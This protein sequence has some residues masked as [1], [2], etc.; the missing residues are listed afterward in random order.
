M[1][2]RIMTLPPKQKKPIFEKKFWERPPPKD[3]GSPNPE[4]VQQAVGWTL[5]Q[6]ELADGN[7][8]HL[9]LTLIGVRRNTMSAVAVRRAYGSIESNSGRRNAV[10]AAGEVY[11]RKYWDH[12][13]VRQTLIDVVNAVQWGAKRRDDVAHGI[14][15]ATIQIA[16]GKNIG[17]F[18][19]P[20]DYN[21]GRS[22]MFTPDPA[23][24]FGFTAAKYRYTADD[25]LSIGSKFALLGQEILD[26]D[27]QLAGGVCG[28][29]IPF[30]DKII[31]DAKAQKKK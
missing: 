26:Y 10:L 8:A 24:P 2:G 22:H 12:I 18:L 28:E 14:T 4:K 16:V 9:F 5:S 13:S 3:Q 6:W 17:S 19:T 21:T 7:L 11:F 31:A 20:P 15:W 30:A 23:G 29:K 27:A 1:E 25:I